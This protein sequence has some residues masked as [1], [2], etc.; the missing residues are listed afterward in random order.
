MN[1]P[2]FWALLA[3][4]AVRGVYRW[5]ASLSKEALKQAEED[6]EK[7]WTLLKALGA[8]AAIIGICAGAIYLLVKLNPH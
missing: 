2:V 1:W 3:A 7:L 5:C 4:F 8:L 6:F